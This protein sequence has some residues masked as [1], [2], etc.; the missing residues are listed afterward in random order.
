MKKNFLFV[1]LSCILVMLF[2]G[3]SA[4]ENLD[5]EVDYS[6]YNFSG[7]QWTRDAECDIETLR[8]LPNGEFR[9]YC[10]CGNS[11]NDSDVVESYSYDDE[12]KIFTLNCYEEIDEMITEIGL[13]NCDGEKL[14]L[15][16]DGE[17]RVFLKEE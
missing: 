13:V 10:A 1:V 14:E 9:Y 6:E 4:G 17:I 15:D 2:A 3:C 5:K 7:V 11:V 12:S 16:F 8:F